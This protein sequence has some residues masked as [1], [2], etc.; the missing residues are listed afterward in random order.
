MPSP[1]QLTVAIAQVA[2]AVLDL[3]GSVERACEVI[4]EAGRRGA[5]L[6]AFPETWLPVYPFWCDAG[7][8]GTWDHG[9]SKR[10]HRRLLE[11]SLE[12]PSP[13]LDRIAAAAR[14]AG[15]AVVLGAN[16]RVRPEAGGGT[17]YNALLF[18]DREGRLVGHRRKLVPTFGERLVWGHGDA[19]DLDAHDL[20][21]FRAGGL[22]CWEHWMPLPR[23]VLH[24]GGEQVHVAAWP[25]GKEHH[26]VASRHYAFEGRC[27]V[28]AAA[29]FLTRDHLPAELA[30]GGELAAL[31]GDGGSE[32]GVLLAGG[33]AVI[34]PDGRYV[35][36]PVYGREELLV[37]Q[38]DL[39]RV[40]EEKLSLDV[41]GHYGR[42]DL[43][44]LTVRR[45]RLR[46]YREAGGEPSR[47]P[48]GSGGVR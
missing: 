43:F 18:L 6:L 31:V 36:E 21:G 47:E 35:V 42:P 1:A 44:D 46:P 8:F 38:I 17:L 23:H 15:V 25:H 9:P 12:V 5:R 30:P 29:L 19:A 2:P 37:A 20:G 16:E 14:E 33:S 28:L 41:A 34:G 3:E 32:D 48:P 40:T 24:A 22:I 11:N 45:D 10:L 4:A 7:T 13:Q 39:D 26:Q 27:Y